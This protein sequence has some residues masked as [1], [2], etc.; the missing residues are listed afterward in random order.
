MPTFT[1]KWGVLAVRQPV[2]SRHFGGPF[3]TPILETSVQMEEY[4]CS[5][6]YRV[7]GS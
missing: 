7:K 2:A 1:G 5:Q 4:Q 6:G 3:F